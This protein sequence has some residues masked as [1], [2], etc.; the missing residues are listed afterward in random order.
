MFKS[1][2]R[3][4][5]ICV[6][7]QS[8]ILLAA[9]SNPVSFDRP[10]TFEPNFGQAPS[11]VSWT[12]R[13]QG[14]QLYLTA[15]GA[16]L[17][18][19]EPASAFPGSA[20]PSA[21]RPGSL[22]G[23]LFGA[24]MSVIAM[25][26][27]G[28]RA[29]TSIDGLEATG[30]I[31]N[32]LLGKTAKNWHKNIPQYGRVRVNDVYDGIDLVFYGR[33]HELEYDFV[34]RPGSDPNRIRLAFDGEESVRVD[35]QTGD[36]LIKTKSGS[37]MRHVRPRVY[38][39]TNRGKVEV[40]GGYQVLDN[41]QAA[42]RLAPYDHR[43][44]LVVD[45]SVE[46]TTF[47]GGTGEDYT[48]G[49]A[50]LGAGYTYVTGQTFSTDFPTTTKT[51]GSSVAKYC[52]DNVCP[53]YIFV[54]ELSPQGKVFSSTLI[55]GS[56]TDTA[57]GIVADSN[58]VWITGTTDSLD[59]ATNNEYGYG[60]WNGFVAKLNPDLGQL[61]WCATFGGVG[62][63]YTNQGSNAIALDANDA[64]YVAGNTSSASF[65]TSESLSM[66]HASKQK[67]L[68]GT[69]DAFVVKIGADGSLNSGYSTYLGGTKDDAAYG[70]AVD[71][72][73]HAYVTGYTGSTN[74]PTNGPTSHGSVANGGTVAFI[75][76]L[77]KDGSSSIYSVL[78]GGT[79]SV[80]HPYPLDQGNAIVLD[81][82]G[83]AYITGTSCTSDFPTDA[84]SFQKMPPSACLPQTAGQYFT[85]AF[86]AKLSSAGSLLY[87]TYLGGTNGAV[88][89]NSIAIDS[90]Q[91]IYVAGLTAT[92]L[93]PGANPITV[94]PSAGFLTK[95]HPKLYT[96]DSTVFLGAAIT[97]I[98][99]FEP[100]LTLV[101]G[102]DTQLPT[103][104]T[105][106]TAGYRYRSGAPAP[107]SRYLDAFV[108]EVAYPPPT[109]P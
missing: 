38:Q 8:P 47:L 75:I 100:Y 97:N 34:V 13:G 93:F 85:S 19:A 95:L 42:F 91:D 43:S 73:G 44:A 30:G 96:I 48:T 1:I 26:L 103:V 108:V 66:P 32:Y 94:N 63:Q 7:M 104:P 2:L 20:A 39:M 83:E 53:A 88:T 10:L 84:N 54:V 90:E 77:S 58:G 70:I 15:T 64:V 79:K 99:E 12:A 61:D 74:F 14:Y 28:S 25:N 98:A 76:E 35:S 27:V 50:R 22:P 41:G 87:S 24:R 69:Q 16:T 46:F 9:A 105:I 62:D 18:M 29:W 59:F 5:V 17:V 37:V 21:G 57:T 89:G 49:L 51:T 109:A 72:S 31:S 107:L 45:P 36:L 56:D 106:L 82:S 101:E 68:G 65:P 33:G 86:V 4:T 52:P 92:G 40:A 6:A 11:Q 55:G 3:T 67:N 81:S 78:L 71:A 23:G 80:Q 60:Y 102:S